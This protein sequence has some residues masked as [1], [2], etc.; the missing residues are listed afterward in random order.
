MNHQPYL[1]WIFYDDET[2]EDQRTLQQQKEFEEHLQGCSYC[3]SISDAWRGTEGCLQSQTM[4]SPSPGF[5]SRWKVRLE[6]DRKLSHRHQTQATLVVSIG[7]AFLL[8]AS[9][10]ILTWP[11]LSS[12]SLLLWTWIYHIFTLY[13]YVELVQEIVIRLLQ[14]ATVAVSISWL[15]ISIGLLSELGVLW[16]VSYRLLTNP[17]R[18][19][20]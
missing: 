11:W 6:E 9:L 15:I 20:R 10:A 3:R 8:L 13:S 5:S 16:I 17:R 14:S 18:I 12:P 19:L 4:I 7:G 1:D 2:V